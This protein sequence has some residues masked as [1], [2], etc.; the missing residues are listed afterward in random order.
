MMD[1]FSCHLF[2]DEGV[3]LGHTCIQKILNRHVCLHRSHF[4]P[5]MNKAVSMLLPQTL[6]TLIT[7]CN[8]F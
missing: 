5:K 3:C 1:L 2:P 7:L 6:N 8:Y 4:Y